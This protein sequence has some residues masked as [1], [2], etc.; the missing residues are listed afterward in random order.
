M[1]RTSSGP[2]MSD[3]LESTEAKSSAVG[4]HPIPG[5][6][7]CCS[8]SMAQPIFRLDEFSGMGICGKVMGRISRRFFQPHRLTQGPV[9]CSDARS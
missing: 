9:E 7:P 5:A 4:L 1:A 3:L 2:S 8:N 6:F